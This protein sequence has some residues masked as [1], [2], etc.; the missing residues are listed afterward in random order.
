MIILG[1]LGDSSRHVVCSGLSSSEIEC[2]AIMSFMWKLGM[3]VKC[4]LAVSVHTFLSTIFIFS[5]PSSA[6]AFSVF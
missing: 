4:S 1:Q 3:H 5:I 2:A 6:L